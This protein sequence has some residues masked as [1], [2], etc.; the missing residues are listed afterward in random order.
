MIQYC[1]YCT[2]AIGQDEDCVY[3]EAKDKFFSKAQCSRPN[4]CKDFSFNE[5]DALGF[6]LNKKYKPRKKKAEITDKQK[7][8]F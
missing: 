3:C 2:E 7:E 8:L 4:K 1:R 6:D 5:I